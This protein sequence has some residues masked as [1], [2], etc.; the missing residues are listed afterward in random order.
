MFHLSYLWFIELVRA[1]DFFFYQIWD[2]L[3]IITSSIFS[4]SFF[5]FSSWYSH[6]AYVGTLGAFLHLLGA[7]FFFFPFSFFFLFVFQIA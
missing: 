4:A 3:V 5:L 6:Y 1:V 7:L 2:V